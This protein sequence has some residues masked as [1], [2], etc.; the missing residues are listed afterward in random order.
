MNLC[1]E[2]ILFSHFLPVASI[3]RLLQEY[4]FRY[5]TSTYHTTVIVIV[6][7]IVIVTVVMLLW[8]LHIQ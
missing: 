3:R 5:S 7:V 1:D 8:W 2:A 4:H 6:I